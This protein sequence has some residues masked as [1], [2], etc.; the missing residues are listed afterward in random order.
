MAFAVVVARRPPSGSKG[1]NRKFQEALGAHAQTVWGTQPR[2][3]GDLYTRI[4]WFCRAAT[5]QDVDNIA[6]N[7]LDALKGVVFDD[8]VSIVQCL[9]CK[10]D[11]RRDYVVSDKNLPAESYD[12]LLRLLA[13][14]N[15]KDVLYIEVGPVPGQKAVFGLIDGG[16]E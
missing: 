2:L 14:P 9:S 15:L 11:L 4:V 16:A 5:T 6:K 7:V 1:R 12:E 13:D 8:D 10:V 3:T